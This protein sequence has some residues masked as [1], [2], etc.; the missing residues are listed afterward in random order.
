MAARRNSVAEMEEAVVQ[1]VKL[2]LNKEHPTWRDIMNN[3]PE[4]I[5]NRTGIARFELGEG[6]VREEEDVN[7]QRIIHSP[8]IRHIHSGASGSR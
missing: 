1:S 8:S 3:L 4:L 6:C 2:R 5:R 7:Q